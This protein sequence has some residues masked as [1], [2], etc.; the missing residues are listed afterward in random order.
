MS[1]AVRA[2]GLGAVAD[3]GFRGPDKDVLDPVIVTGSMLAA[4]T[5][6]PPA[7]KSPTASWPSDGH[8]Y[9][10]GLA[11]LKNWRTLTELRTYPAR[12]WVRTWS[13]RAAVLSWVRPRWAA[14]IHI[15][16][17]LSSVRARKCRP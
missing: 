12:R 7:K 11:H 6:S 4:L 17:L 9:E 3:L 15:S 5:S 8:R 13:W 10:H 1:W 14:D 2:A 16:R